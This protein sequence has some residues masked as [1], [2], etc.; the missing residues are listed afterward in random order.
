MTVDTL[1]FLDAVAGLP[2]QLAHAHEIAGAVHV[3]AFPRGDS[4]RNIVV[5]GMG[6]SG[7]SGEPG[8]VMPAFCNMRSASSSRP[9]PGFSIASSSGVIS[10]GP[11]SL[12]SITASMSA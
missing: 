2:E 5:L 10:V 7:I 6:G 3:D 12:R 4:I 11:R 9:E 1:N 8:Q